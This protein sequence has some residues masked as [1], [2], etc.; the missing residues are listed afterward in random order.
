MTSIVQSIIFD[1]SKWDEDTA[2]EWLSKHDYKFNKIDNKPNY[3]RARQVAPITLNN[4]GYKNYITKRLKTKNSL[5]GI[6]LIIALK[7]EL[8][9]GSLTS[10]QVNEFV[11]ASY[12]KNVGSAA[13]TIEPNYKLDTGLSTKEVKVYHDATAQ[14]PVV[15][16][17]R[18]TQGTA[19]D[20]ANN[21][22]YAIGQYNST[23]RMQ[24]AID[25]QKNAIKKYGKVDVNVGHSQG[26]VI[27]RRLNEKGLTDQIINVNPA[28]MG[29]KQ[30][31]NETIVKSS[32]DIVSLL[33]P[34]NKK[35]G[36]VII[37]PTGYNPLSEHSSDILKR[38]D[39]NTMI[40]KGID[41]LKKTLTDEQ[42]VEILKELK[43][44]Y[45]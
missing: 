14:D 17:N 36:N 40:G 25:V 27:T 34:T 12:A 18:G 43:I 29:E 37:K 20:W 31:K 11:N 1:K 9:G 13:Q 7:E 32:S 15:V 2:K 19:K 30:K 26:A 3:I 33:Q 45:C 6:E 22:M 23:D 44:K 5:N 16:V 39:P 41:K 24:N 21:A 8:K 10:K 38:I 42:V 35:K 28:S 4:K